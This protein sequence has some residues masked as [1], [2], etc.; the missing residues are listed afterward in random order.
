VGGGVITV[1]TNGNYV[2]RSPLWDSGGL[3]DV[4]AVT[5]G[6]GTNGVTG[7]VGVANSLVGSSAG[8]QVGSSGVAALTNGNY[9]VKSGLWNDGSVHDVGA[10]TFGNGTSGIVGAVSSANSLVGGA[11]SDQVGSGLGFTGVLPLLNGSYI[12]LSPK[13]DNDA[14]LD[15]GAVTF[16]NGGSGISGPLDTTN[17]LVGST[18]GDQVGGGSGGS[19]LVRRLANGNYVVGSRGWDNG[20]LP[21]AGAVTFG[22]GSSGISGPIDATNSVIGGAA[23]T[24]LQPI[25][26]D[27]VNQTFYAIFPA[28]GGGH[29]RVGS[30]IDGFAHHWHL[31]AKPNDI[32]NDGHVAPGDA[33]SII[34][35][36]NAGFPTAVPADATL[37]KPYGF[38]DV[39]GDDFVSPGDALAVINTIN[40]GQGGEGEGSRQGGFGVP[41]SAGGDRGQGTGDSAVDGALLMLL[42]T[43]VNGQTGKR[44][45]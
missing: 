6:D 22:N 17:S 3:L 29:V 42:A 20:L 8:D 36:I 12:V 23:N 14:A 45:A 2:V 34:N 16:G 5:F 1:L 41:G 28:E 9:V 30:Q 39:D 18:A 21:D 10:V 33:L 7:A 43:D 4:G 19:L 38:L 44:R 11:A 32:N 25:V 13:W 24:N 35:Y 26:V 37:G 27:D 31:A 15:A 40:A